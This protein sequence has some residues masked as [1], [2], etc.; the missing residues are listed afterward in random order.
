MEVRNLL[1]LNDISLQGIDIKEMLAGAALMDDAN[2]TIL[3]RLFILLSK[4][5]SLIDLNDC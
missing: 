5:V 4:L 3:V 1:T 2:K